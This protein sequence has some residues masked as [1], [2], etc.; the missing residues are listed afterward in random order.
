MKMK[1]LIEIMACKEGNEMFDKIEEI[2]NDFH[3]DVYRKDGTI[4]DLYEVCCDVAD[5]WNMQR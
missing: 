3:I 5:V 1:A 2:L 4:K